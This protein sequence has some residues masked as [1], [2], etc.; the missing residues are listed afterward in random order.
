MCDY[1]AAGRLAPAPA[2][3][4]GSLWSAVDCARLSACSVPGSR[5]AWHTGVVVCKNYVRVL[6]RPRW[7][8]AAAPAD[9]GAM[10]CTAPQPVC[11]YSRPRPLERSS[12]YGGGTLLG[13]SRFWGS[14]KTLPT[15]ANTTFATTTWTQEPPAWQAHTQRRP[16]ASPRCVPPPAAPSRPAGHDHPRS[17][18]GP[19]PVPTPVRPWALLAQGSAGA[20]SRS[21]AGPPACWPAAY[22][23]E[24][25][26]R[27]AKQGVGLGEHWNVHGRAVWLAGCTAARR[28]QRAACTTT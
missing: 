26:L 4:Y 28:G 27:G 21:L 19:T 11:Y 8:F 18:A 2:P 17:P 15:L 6:V 7:P 10:A 1:C 9:P 5:S 24:A 23:P 14:Q 16:A 20:G 22:T 13:V 12:K 25:A 3:G